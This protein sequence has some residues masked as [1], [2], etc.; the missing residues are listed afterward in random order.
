MTQ[1]TFTMKEFDD[2]TFPLGDGARKIFLNTSGKNQA[3]ISEDLREFLDYVKDPTSAEL[4]SEKVKAIDNRVSKVKLD[5]E[6]RSKYMT[7]EEWI[8]DQCSLIS[9]HA[10]E[11]GKRKG[12]EEGKIESK[13]EQ[14]RVKYKKKYGV[15]KTAEMLEL[16]VAFVEEIYQ[17]F[18]S[19]PEENDK[20]IT[21]RY[22]R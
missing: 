2:L 13:V 1:E 17:L 7:L 12:L 10:R 9:E 3:E 16:D 14:I 11:Q 18:Q 19:Y 5:M 20:Q 4:K 22:L 21:M 8:D 15:E 6:V